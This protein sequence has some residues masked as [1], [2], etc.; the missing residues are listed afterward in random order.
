MSYHIWSH[1]HD[2]WWGPDR[3]GYTS[4]IERA[5]KYSKAEAADIVLS[6]LPGANVAVDVE[7]AKNNKA[8][9]GSTLDT[10]KELEVLRRL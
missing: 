2:Q 3:A 5:G 8:L 6:S 1:R 10:K 7:L 9:T 4:H